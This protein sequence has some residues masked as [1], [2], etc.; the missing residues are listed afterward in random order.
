MGKHWRKYSVGKYRLGRLN[1]QAVVIWKDSTGPHR[2]RLGFAASEVA[3]RGLLDAWVR[4]AAIIRAEES[5]TVADLWD[6]Y[7]AD[8]IQDG[9][10]ASNFKEAWKALKPRFASLPVDAVT[11]DVCRDY[12][13]HRIAQK[14]SQGTVW[15]ELTKLRSCLN[16]AVKRRVIKSAPYVWMP[17][18]P[19][20]RQRVLTPA[21]AIKLIDHCIMPH[22]RLFMILA[23]T[24]GA[25][26]GALLALTWDRVDLEADTIDLREPE[27]ID[28]LTKKVRKSRSVVPITSVAKAA[29]MEAKKSA[30]SDFVIEWDGERVKNIRNGFDAARRRAQIANV[31]PHTIRHTAAS[32]AVNDGASMEFAAKLLGHRNPETTRR[33][34]AKPD[35]DSLRPTANIIDMKIRRKGRAA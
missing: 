30:L 1:G 34:Y 13:K 3:A 17:S 6:A 9:K 32:W 33:I 14:A 4:R 10:Q 12:T 18:K 26:K 5:K 15:T 7:E 8:R 24:T 31:T 21:E 29:L 16:W 23:L 25:R 2:R 11:A 27:L 22:V 28:P 20:P 35:V 19:P